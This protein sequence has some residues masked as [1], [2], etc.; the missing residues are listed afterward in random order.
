MVCR[1]WLVQRLLV[2]LDLVGICAILLWNN[3]ESLNQPF[4][5]NDTI[6]DQF[7]MWL[8]KSIQISL[9]EFVAIGA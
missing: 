1:H 8:I 7:E 4:R 2:I 6:I 9:I 5:F 3:E